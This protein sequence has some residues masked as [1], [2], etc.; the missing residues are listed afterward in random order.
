MKDVKPC[1]FQIKHQTIKFSCNLEVLEDRD[2][3]KDSNENNESS[4]LSPNN[5][6]IKEEEIIKVLTDNKEE[7][8]VSHDPDTVSPETV[9]PTQLEDESTQ[10]THDKEIDSDKENESEEESENE[11]ACNP[12]NNVGGQK[13]DD[14]YDSSDDEN[15]YD[16]NNG[17]KGYKA[18]SEDQ[19]DDD[20]CP[21][22]S[23]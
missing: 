22:I 3:T 17:G 18:A 14:S 15:E 11:S 16:S 19:L 20:L 4:Q 7:E 23:R 8:K 9:T 6:Q 12:I 5:E 13:D 10:N 21:Q 2:D 1:C